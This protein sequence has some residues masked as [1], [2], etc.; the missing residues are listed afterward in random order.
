MSKIK[1]ILKNSIYAE[2]WKE[3][4][5]FRDGIIRSLQILAFAVFLFVYGSVKGC[6]KDSCTAKAQEKPVQTQENKKV[7]MK[8]IFD[9]AKLFNQKQR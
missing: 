9:T 7:V 2:M 8:N 3:N 6:N 5:E 4:S 1:N